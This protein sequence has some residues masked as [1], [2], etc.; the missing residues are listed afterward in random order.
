[1]DD[2]VPICCFCS[3]VRDDK[4]VE[5]GQGSWVDLNIYAGSR[6]L[7]LKHGF[8]FSHGDCSDCIAHYGE[9][10]VAHRAKRFWESLKERGRSLLA[11]A[12]GRQ[13]GEK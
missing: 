10:M 6:Q 11:E 13:R 2:L 4:G 5:L 9:R 7:P 1:M 8:V 3:K 12:G